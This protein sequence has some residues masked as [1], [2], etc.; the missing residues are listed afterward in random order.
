MLKK[1]TSLCCSV[2]KIQCIFS[3]FNNGFDF[4][5]KFHFHSRTGHWKTTRTKLSTLNFSVR[6][7]RILIIP[8]NKWKLISSSFSS[9]FSPLPRSHGLK[10]KSLWTKV[11]INF[12]HLMAVHIVFL[13]RLVLYKLKIFIML[14]N[15]IT[16]NEIQRFQQLTYARWLAQAQFFSNLSARSY[17][18]LGSCLITY[19]TVLQPKPLQISCLKQQKKKPTIFVGGDSSKKML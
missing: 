6:L 10:K 3:T 5:L 1:Y 18:L 16:E 9:V 11:W 7:V 12:E 17:H 4:L 8:S 13:Q 15:I 19:L 14:C 2:E